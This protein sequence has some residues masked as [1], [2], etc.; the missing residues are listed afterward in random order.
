MKIYFEMLWD[1][2]H[3]KPKVILLNFHFVDILQ[4]EEQ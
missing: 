4:M 1:I 2:E 3:I